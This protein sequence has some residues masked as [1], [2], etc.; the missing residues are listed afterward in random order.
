MGA[1]SFGQPQS[2]FRW[3]KLLVYVDFWFS[4]SELYVTTLHEIPNHITGAA[5][6]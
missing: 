6:V 4:V 2:N 5:I 1:E 3:N